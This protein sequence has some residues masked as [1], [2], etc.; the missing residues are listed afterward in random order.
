[1]NSIEL[2]PG[3]IKYTLIFFLLLIFWS[4]RQHKT[5]DIPEI[6]YEGREAVS[7][8]F[9]SNEETTDLHVTIKGDQ[10]PPI[11]GNL[12]WKTDHFEFVPLIPFTPGLTYSLKSKEEELISFEIPLQSKQNAR[13]QYWFPQKDTVPQNLLKMYLGFSEQM[14]KVQDP[15]QYI[16]VKDLSNGEVVPIFLSLENHLWNKDNTELTLWLDPGR[17]KKDLIPN[18][19]S[20]TPL[21]ANKKYEFIIS[22]QWPTASGAS[23]DHSYSRTFIVTA[24]DNNKLDI[25]KIQLN[26]I[27]SNTLRNLN[28][29]FNDTWDL[30][31]AMDAI[32][33]LKENGDF[34]EGE[35]E[36]VQN[37]YGLKFKPH[38]N[39]QPG[40]YAILIETRAE[41]LAGNNLLRLFDTDLT[42][43]EEIPN[44]ESIIIPFEVK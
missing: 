43:N 33:I 8:K 22:E 29:N 2:K 41:D 14:N 40:K 20:G 4:C 28:I 11:L 6:V 30:I 9:Y 38:K 31:V 42:S 35:L 26:S 24:A 44:N 1:M 3:K 27:Q 15:L 17:I 39:W 34:V 25:N 21:I 16:K 19:E 13:L 7:V 12:L 37:L 36:P 18:K 10:N 23:L 5:I 32:Q